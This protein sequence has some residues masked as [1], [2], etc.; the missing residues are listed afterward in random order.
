MSAADGGERENIYPHDR[1]RGPVTA[2]RNVLLQTSLNE[3]QENGHYERYVQLIAPE[4]LEQLQTFLAP[5]WVPIEIA[6]AHYAACNGLDLSSAQSGRLGARIG[7]RLQQTLFVSNAKGARDPDFD[8][9]KVT[10]GLYRMWAR[11]YQGGSV[12]LTRLGEHETLIGQLGFTLNRYEYYRQ[13][14]M[15]AIAAAYASVGTRI[16]RFDIERYDPETHEIEFHMAW[17]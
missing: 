9:W 3:L 8:L 11:L 17:L 14:Q 4:K 13:A 15:R 7:N 6:D 12:Q 5:G 10:P 16:T 2:V 1:T